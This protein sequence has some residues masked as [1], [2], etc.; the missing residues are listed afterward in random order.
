MDPNL[1]ESFQIM[2][3]NGPRVTVNNTYV[4][5]S[6]RVLWI[7]RIVQGRESGMKETIPHITS[8]LVVVV[9]PSWAMKT[10]TKT[11]L[12]TRRLV[13][14]SSEFEAQCWHG[15]IWHTDQRCV[16][17]WWSASPSGLAQLSFLLGLQ[18]PLLFCCLT[19]LVDEFTLVVTLH[20]RP[21][22]LTDNTCSAERVAAP[23]MEQPLMTSLQSA[24][25][26]PYSDYDTPRPGPIGIHS[27]IIIVRRTE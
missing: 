17:S 19:A 24:G 9:R 6:P 26:I 25:E 12:I 4:C 16:W 22:R 20:Q 5:A 11:I 10:L 13:T 8:T 1:D 23:N 7:I 27:V 2:I 14:I 15:M 18:S 3:K 21:L